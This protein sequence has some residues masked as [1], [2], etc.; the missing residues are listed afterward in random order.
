MPSPTI[1]LMAKTDSIFKQVAPILYLTQVRARARANLSKMIFHY[2][3]IILDF[4]LELLEQ[5]HGITTTKPKKKKLICANWENYIKFQENKDYCIN[6]QLN[7]HN[8]K[9]L[10]RIDCKISLQ[11]PSTQWS[12]SCNS[13]SN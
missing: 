5:I 9:F 4:I 1:I 13:S 11:Q 2:H 8:L 10:N 7:F 3:F 12:R 6:H